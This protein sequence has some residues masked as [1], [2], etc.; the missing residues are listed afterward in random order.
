MRFHRD[1]HVTP[2]QLSIIAL[3]AVLI[4][5]ISCA[6]LQDDNTQSDNEFSPVGS[7]L[8]ARCIADGECSGDRICVEGLCSIEPPA[9]QIGYGLKLLPGTTSGVPRQQLS[10]QQQPAVGADFV[11]HT[12]DVATGEITTSDGEPL[13]NATLIA[14]SEQRPDVQIQRP[15]RDGEFELHIPPGD[16]ALTL[17]VDDDRWPRLDLG[18]V[19]VED[20]PPA[21]TFEVPTLEQFPVVTGELTRD[22]LELLDILTEPVDGADIVARSTDSDA[23]SQFATTDDDG[24]FE[25]RLPDDDET[26]D[27]EIFPGDDNPLVP[28]ATFEQEITP[29]ID[30]VELSLGELD[31][32]LLELSLQVSADPDVDH[33]DIDYSDLRVQARQSVDLGELLVVPE[34][35]DDGSAELDLP[36]GSWDIDVSTAP[37]TP[38]AGASEQASLLDTG[39]DVQL[40]LPPRLTTEG[41]VTDE[42]GDELEGVRIK[43]RDLETGEALPAVRSDE[44]GQ[45]A[46]Y[47]DPGDYELT[48][49]PPASAALPT[50]L[51]QFTVEDE[52]TEIDAA[53]P[54][55]FVATGTVQTPEG[56]PLADTGVRAVTDTTDRSIADATTDTDGRFRLIVPPELAEN[57]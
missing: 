16:Y 48:F 47:A 56:T 10:V 55:G 45:F 7:E 35:D 21:P 13:P 41:R 44:A 15:V 1:I 38:F 20:E 25:L 11:A 40:E 31:L 17:V 39:S 33:A 52:S 24:Q 3:A 57:P 46:F 28:R 2:A 42:E 49:K 23:L 12:T 54:Y 22:A 5:A 32:E 6:E 53:I 30:S 18:S 34:L 19:T 14:M 4:A 29:G 51:K 27:V 9:E 37:G 50:V 26:Y 36:L 8:D 43:P